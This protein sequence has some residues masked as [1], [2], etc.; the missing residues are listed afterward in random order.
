MNPIATFKRDILS[1]QTAS[2]TGEIAHDVARLATV[3]GFSVVDIRRYLSELSNEGLILL[4]KYDGVGRRAIGGWPDEASFWKSD[5]D[6]GHIWVC[7]T[8]RGRAH[9]TD[10]R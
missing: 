2:P 9:L 6:A 4:T 7:V 10:M 8:P 5:L 1:L 3:Y